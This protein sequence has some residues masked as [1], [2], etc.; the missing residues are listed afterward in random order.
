MSTTRTQPSERAETVASDDYPLTEVP[1]RARRGFLSL[2]T[3]LLGFVFFTPTMLAGARISTAFYW[4]DLLAVL[5]VG[6]TI[7]GLYVAFLAVIGART[8]LTTVLLARYT[9]GRYGAKWA[10]VLLGGTQVCWYAVTAVFISELLVQAFGLEGY[11]WVVIVLSSVLTGITAYYGFRGLEVLS[12]LSVPLMLALCCWVVFQ[13]LDAVGGWGGLAEVAPEESMPWATAVTIV[14]GTFVSGGTQTP[15]WSRFAR[16]PWQAFVAALGAFL[17][18]N[19]L[20]LVF[21]AVGAIA[22]Q[23]GDFVVVLLQLNLVLAAVTLLFF[24]VWTTQE[25]TAYAFGVAG[26][27]MFGLASKRPFI[28][29]GIA[30]AILLALTG[31]YEALPQYLLLLGIFIPPLGGVIIGDHLFV[32]RGSLRKLSRTRFL[33]VRWSC[34]SAYV[35]GTVVAFVSDQLAIGLPPVQGILTAIVAVPVAERLFRAWGVE[36]RHTSVEEQ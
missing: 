30:V 18:G 31:I 10:S 11:T 17:I 12:G 13:A 29:A 15:N 6:S 22:F 32:W 28:I 14:V 25:T 26:A 4:E 1:L 2:L 27:E 36:T 19:L 23:A 7:L 8:G 21:G 34:L 35:L 20:M 16:L 5:I 24:N 33:A 9:L 3:V